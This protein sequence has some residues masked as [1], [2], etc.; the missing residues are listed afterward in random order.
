MMYL[1]MSHFKKSW[2][3]ECSFYYDVLLT[4]H[5]KHCLWTLWVGT[6]LSRFDFFSSQTFLRLTKFIDKYSSNF[7][8][9]QIYYGNIF[10]ET[11]LMFKMLIFFINLIKLN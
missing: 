1:L 11:N 5:H 7:N 4:W 3:V 9:K 6:T 8:T 10:N 2:V